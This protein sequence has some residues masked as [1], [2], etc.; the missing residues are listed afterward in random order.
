M[1]PIPPEGP[2]TPAPPPPPA[3][4]PPVPPPTP[5]YVDD[6][7]FDGHEPVG[8]PP[9]PAPATPAPSGR[10]TP[11]PPVRRARWWPAVVVVLALLLLGGAS[12]ATVA[13]MSPASTSAAPRPTPTTTAPPTTSVPSTTAPKRS[14]P[15]TPTT[16][17]DQG[18]T[19]SGSTGRSNGTSGNQAT[20]ADWSSA[21]AAINP[22]VVNI[23]TRLANG[24]GAGTGMILTADG[25]ILTNNHVI[26]GATTI[27]VTTVADGKTYRAT[28]VG[29][30]AS[31]DIAV[32]KLTGASGLSPIAL[33]DSDTVKVGDAVAAMGNAGGKGGEP[34][35]APGTI[36]NLD[37]QITATDEQGGGAE[38]LD[39]MIEVAANVQPGDSGGPLVASDAKV[40]GIDTAASAGNGRYRVTSGQGYAIPI[41]HALEV[42][43]ELEA[44]GQGA[45]G[46]TA[47]AAFLGVQ[48][49][50]T[51]TGAQVAGVE[52]GSPA[53]TAGIDAGSVITTFDGKPVTSAAALSTAIRAHHSGDSVAIGWTG[54]DGRTH[55]ATLALG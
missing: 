27:A 24:I 37:Q 33:G 55:Q 20:S 15:S 1:P 23:E 52:N 22:G 28:V 36:T 2:F 18:G 30:D 49:M 31:E 39:G 14:T 40:V 9:A 5:P 38:T 53:E 54:A 4:W 44:S 8:G 47:S 19:G 3:V 17:D 21:S 13:R 51:T 26:D 29:A 12:Y 35:V 41:N 45:N 48:I 42:A 25:T 50:D 16:P 6:P 11:G 34:T 46:T 43:K 32:I 10:P 7:R